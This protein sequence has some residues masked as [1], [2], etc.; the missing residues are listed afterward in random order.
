MLR[1]T[2]MQAPS[3][4]QGQIFATIRQLWVCWCGAPSLTRGQVCHLQLL[5]AL[6]S[7]VILGSES[8]RTHDHISPSQIW[9]SPN[10]VGQVPVSMSPRNMVARL[11]LR[12]RVP[13]KS[14]H[15]TR[16]AVVEVFEP[17][18]TRVPGSHAKVM[19]WLTVCRPAC[20]GVKL[21]V[22]PKIRFLLLSRKLQVC[23]CGA[24]SLTRGRVCRFRQSCINWC[25][26]YT[27]L[28]PTTYKTLLP[29]I[30]PLLSDVLSRLLP[31]DGLGTADT[32]MCFCA[33]ETC[34]PAV[35]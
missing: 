17:A 20:L 15:T 9:D 13:L 2:V 16:W 35:A 30:P 29:K 7:A 6:A 8:H 14:P 5:L 1:L 24:P 18:S 21:H 32:G 4:A 25:P 22:G 23:S 11:Y 12:H 34:L 31:S 27:T 33:E 26:R 28:A 3:G 19:L 10:L